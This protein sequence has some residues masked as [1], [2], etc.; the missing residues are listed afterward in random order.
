M[1]VSV[2]QENLA[3]KLNIV[4]RAVPSR[5]S[6]PVLSNILL[7]AEEGG[8]RLSATNLELGITARLGGSVD[9][10]GAIT[11]P[12][13]TF[14]DLVNTLPNDRVD[15][16][17]DAATNTLTVRCNRTV[18]N[19]K[20]IE[21]DQFPAVPES[22]AETGIEIPAATF[23]AMI[24]QVVF[25][26]AKEDNRPVL[27][28]VQAKFD[29]S[30]LTLISADGFRMALRSTALDGAVEKPQTLIIPA[31]TLAELSRIISNEAGSVYISIPPGRNQVMFHMQDTDIVS[32]LIDG[33][34]PDVEA[35]IPKSSN[36]VSTLLTADLLLACRRCEIFARE[37]NNTMRLRV[38]PGEGG[39]LGQVI[40]TAQAQER[41]DNEGS[42]EAVVNG[43]GLEISFNVRY[44]IDVLNVMDAEQVALEMNTAASPGVFKPSGRQDFVYV[45]MPMSVR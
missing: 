20:G 6:M 37:A 16:E 33:K 38:K 40:I 10:E 27:M 1:R 7:A 44:L 18:A 30:K 34:F 23:Q 42:V 26:A 25:A 21:A 35:L 31:R 28:G 36:T 4:S 14:L 3:K 22:D 5:P 11:I 24:D 8:I 45:V 29:P 17:L 19:I 41:G 43:P 13:R 39:N 9:E 12:A 15:L 2:L 32:Q